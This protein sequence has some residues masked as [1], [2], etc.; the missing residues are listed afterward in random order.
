MACEFQL[1]LWSVNRQI[2]AK[3]VLTSVTFNFDLDL[4][5]WTL[6]LSMVITPENFMMIRS[7][8][9]CQKCVT[10]GQTEEQTDGDV[11]RAAQSQLNMVA[12]SKPGKKWL[13]WNFNRI[14]I[15][16]ERVLSKW[17]AEGGCDHTGFFWIR[18][19]FLSLAR[20][21]LRLCSANHRPGY[22]SNLPCDWPSTVWAYSKQE[23]ENGPW[24]TSNNL[25]SYIFT[26]NT[27]H[28]QCEQ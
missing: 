10:N 3:F 27:D 5:A 13:K 4:F 2:R 24:C 9:H 20:S 23:T 14:W 18:A 11:H 17:F 16:M 6:R 19:R 21:K 12:I 28:K 7:Q 26:R 15:K 25:P 1:Q 22:W 8:E